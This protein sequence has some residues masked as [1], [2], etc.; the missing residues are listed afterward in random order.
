VESDKCRV[1][2]EKPET[3]Q[4]IISGC[5][6]LAPTE[7]KERHDN[8]AKIVQMTLLE[9]YNLNKEKSIH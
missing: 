1:C 7:Y 3:I 6:K 9:E 8:V 4:H 2:G 5:E